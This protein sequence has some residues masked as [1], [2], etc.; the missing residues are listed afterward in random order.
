MQNA[1][2]LMILIR[3]THLLTDSLM[4][5][6]TIFDWTTGI[7]FRKYRHVFHIRRHFGTLQQ[8][9]VA[10]LRCLQSELIKSQ[11]LSTGLQYPTTSFL[12][13]TQGTHLPT[14]QHHHKS[15]TQLNTFGEHITFYFLSANSGSR[16]IVLFAF[17][18]CTKYK[19]TEML[20]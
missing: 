7:T 17:P 4:M 3:N 19:G 5:L 13:H 8:N 2:N 11:Y 15:S 10:T 9:G 16:D 6:R 18:A 14:H 12:R 20:H 1:S